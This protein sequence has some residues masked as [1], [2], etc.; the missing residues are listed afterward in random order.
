MKRRVNVG[1]TTCTNQELIPNYTTNL[2]KLKEK[3]KQRN[4][5]IYQRKGGCGGG[6]DQLTGQ[7]N[8]S[9]KR[10]INLLFATN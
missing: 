10:N 3:G 9:T 6:G 4:K 7:E 1:G 5:K 8:Q 2:H